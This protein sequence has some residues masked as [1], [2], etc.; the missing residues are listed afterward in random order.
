M[1][2]EASLA[3][4]CADPADPADPAD[5]RALATRS[6]NA[7]SVSSRPYDRR[8]ERRSGGAVDVPGGVVEVEV[9]GDQR[10]GAGG[11]LLVGGNSYV[12]RYSSDPEDV[13]DDSRG[14][15]TEEDDP[16]GDWVVDSLVVVVSSSSSSSSSST[17]Q[18]NVVLAPDEYE[19][20]DDVPL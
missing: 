15:E 6:W 4:A 17:P 1:A 8:G 9:G 10:P 14:V 12:G 20:D 16:H 19:Y 3:A 11:V 2:Y 18:S 7:S 5:A 13:D